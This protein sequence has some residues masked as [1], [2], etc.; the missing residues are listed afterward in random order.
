MELL[1][2][3]IGKWERQHPNG[4]EDLDMSSCYLFAQFLA[5][6]YIVKIKAQYLAFS[7][8]RSTSKLRAILYKIGDELSTARYPENRREFRL[9]PGHQLGIAEMMVSDEK[10]NAEYARPLGWY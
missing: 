6:A 9:W 4:A 7:D 5:W 10:A 3:D 2:G 8:D 1:G